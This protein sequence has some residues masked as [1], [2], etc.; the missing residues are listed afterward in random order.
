MVKV[1]Q[2]KSVNIQ[3]VQADFLKESKIVLIDCYN[4]EVFQEKIC[5][6]RKKVFHILMCVFEAQNKGE[7]GWS[8][9][10]LHGTY[11]NSIYDNLAKEMSPSVLFLLFFLIPL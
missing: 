1:R 5:S 8:F 11:N 10:F 7:P 2:S 6:K 4:L 9:V 3:R